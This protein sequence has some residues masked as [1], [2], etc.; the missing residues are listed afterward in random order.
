M[1]FAFSSTSIFTFFV[2]FEALLIPLFFLIGFFGT[3]QRRV[4]AAFYLVFYTLVG[5]IPLLLG[6]FYV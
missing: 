5:S 2:S 6:I 1:L 4:K 3:R